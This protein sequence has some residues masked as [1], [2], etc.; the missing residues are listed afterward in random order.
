M[1]KPFNS[2]CNAKLSIKVKIY[3]GWLT[4]SV[5]TMWVNLFSLV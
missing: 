4:L 2:T 3:G 5:L 1:R